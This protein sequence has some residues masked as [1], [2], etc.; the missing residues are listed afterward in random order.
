MFVTSRRECFRNVNMFSFALLKVRHVMSPLSDDSGKR[1]G[2]NEMPDFISLQ[3]RTLL[4]GLLS[5]IFSLGQVS[6]ELFA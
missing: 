6:R 3:L 5:N 1:D 4:Y 2:V